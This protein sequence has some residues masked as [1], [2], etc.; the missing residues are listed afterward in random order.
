MMRH[1]LVVWGVLLWSVPTTG[2]QYAAFTEIGDSITV[3]GQRQ[4]EARPDLEALESARRA[5]G[6]TGSARVAF[7]LFDGRTL[8]AVLDATGPTSAGYFLA[9]TVQG[10]PYSSVTVVVNGEIVAGAVRASGAVYEVAATDP[11]VHVIRQVD[12]TLPLPR[13]T[14][15]SP[16]RR[17]SVPPRGAQPIRPPE[18]SPARSHVTGEDGSRIDVLVVYTRKARTEHGGTSAIRALVDLMAVGTNQAYAASGVRQ[19]INLAHVAEVDYD[20]SGRDPDQ[21]ILRGHLVTPSDG[22]LDNVHQLRNRY[23]ADIVS[24]IIVPD[25]PDCGG[26]AYLISKPE[27][28]E[29]AFNVMCHIDGARGAVIFAHELGHNMGLGHDRYEIESHPRGRRDWYYDQSLPYGFG[30]VNQRMFDPGAPAS[31]RWWTIMA[32]GLQCWE[33]AEEN[34]YSDQWCRGSRLADVLL[35]FS[36]PN[37]QVNGDPTG[38][39]GG[40]RI[41]ALDGPADA[42]RWL[43][44][45]RRIVANWREA[46]CLR[47]EMPVRLQAS[48]GQYVIAVGNGGGAV[49]AN[50][51]ARSRRGIFRVDHRRGGCVESGDVVSFHTSDGFYLRVRGGGGGEVDATAPRATPWARF[52]VTQRAVGAPPDSGARALE[53]HIRVGGLVT[54]QAQQ[55]GLYVAAEEGGG[56]QLRADGENVSAWELFKL[57]VR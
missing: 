33:W 38:V 21:I 26:T 23:A 46:P 48:N 44:A 10:Q 11:P 19:R 37:R 30:Y 56:G 53:G 43:N 42:R 57:T 45:K 25:D 29:F 34:G 24:L 16:P 17:P 13:D 20:E 54:L 15:L 8:T 55:S 2:Q 39:P 7:P 32:Y 18:P 49:L 50:Q 27:D 5:V 51:R 1:L 36:N 35:R 40:R 9:G 41:K 14:V 31:A 47:D 28:A 12:P 4:V 3:D 22:H 52:V 6:A